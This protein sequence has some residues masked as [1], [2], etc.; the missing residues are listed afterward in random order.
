MQELKVIKHLVFWFN[1]LKHSNLESTIWENKTIALIRT[2][3]S[4][5]KGVLEFLVPF[6]LAKKK[7]VICIWENLCY[8][9]R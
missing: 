9:I 1:N 7:E 2:I 3:S 6:N 8:S 5:T 4:S